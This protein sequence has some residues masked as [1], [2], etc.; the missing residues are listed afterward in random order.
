MR[1][2]AL[3]LGEHFYRLNS[4][5]VATLLRAKGIRVGKR[6]YIQGV[7]KIKIGGHAKDISIG[8][9]VRIMGDVDLRNREQGSIRIGDDVTIDEGCRFI[10]ANNAIL[11]IGNGTRIGLCTVFNCGVNVSIGENVLI[12]GFCYIQSSNHGIKS[13]Y[14]IQSQPHT[15]G[16]INVGNNSWLG[17]HVTVLPGVSIGDGAVIG[18]KAVVTKEVFMD[19]IVAGIP[20]KVIGKRP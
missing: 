7:P 18:A 1:I 15:Y 11:T 4:L 14:P 12:S 2:L 17:S 9:N 6:F 19:T 3:I 16:E 8:R 20:A 13:G 10:A 5:L